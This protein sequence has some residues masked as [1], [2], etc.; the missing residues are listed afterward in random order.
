MKSFVFILTIFLI[1]GCGS[2]YTPK[3]CDYY[4]GDFIK[5]ELPPENL[6]SE[7]TKDYL[8]YKASDG[9]FFACPELQ[10]K[11]YCSAYHYESFKLEES[12]NYKH[13]EIICLE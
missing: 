7:T 4:I 2:T 11:N 12:G 6:V 10:N 3:P 8:W 1:T 5:Q 13:D 9:S